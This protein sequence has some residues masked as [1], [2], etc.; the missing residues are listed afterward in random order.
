MVSPSFVNGILLVGGFHFELQLWKLLKLENLVWKM[1]GISTLFRFHSSNFGNEIQKKKKSNFTYHFGG[2]SPLLSNIHES[3]V[4]FGV[5]R[6]GESL[7]S[8]ELQTTN[9]K[10]Q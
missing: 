6:F 3:L 7:E 10:Y 2:T 1:G 5:L 8:L 9:I 4:F